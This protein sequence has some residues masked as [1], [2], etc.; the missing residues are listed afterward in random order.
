M[1]T[2]EIQLK[3]KDLDNMRKKV[4]KKTTLGEACTAAYNKLNEYCTP[5]KDQKQTHSTIATNCDPQLNL[6]VF[7]QLWFLSSQA[8]QRGRTRA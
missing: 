1:S 2:H 4:G 7:D 8:E 6:R 3:G 5:A